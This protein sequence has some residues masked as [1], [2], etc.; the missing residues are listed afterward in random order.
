MGHRGESADS[1]LRLMLVFRLAFTA[2]AVAFAVAGLTAR[3]YAD[4]L[5]VNNSGSSGCYENIQAAIAAV[6]SPAT[7]IVIAPGTYSATCYNP[8]CAVAAVAGS[9]NLNGLTLRCRSVNGRVAVLNAAGL[10]HAIYI[11]GVNSVTVEGCVVENAGREGILVENADNVRIKANE[12]RRNDLSLLHTGGCPSVNPAGAP[13]PGGGIVPF[14]CPDAWKGPPLLANFPDDNDDCGEG[15]H[16]RS[17]TDA[18]VQGNFV[19]GN[20]GGILITDETGV[21]ENNLIF[22]N[23]SR[24]NLGDCGITLAS[25]VEC[26]AGS[27][28]ATGCS[29]GEA[30]AGYGV[31]H[32]SVVGN[33]SI[34]NGAAGVGAFANP[35]A[36]PGAATVASGN[37]ISDNITR[38]NGHPGVSIHAHAG[39]SNL[40]N[41]VIVENVVSGNGGDPESEGGKAPSTIGIELFSASAALVGSGFLPASPIRGTVI[42]QNKVSDEDIDVWVGATQTDARVLLNDLNGAGKTGILN[43]GSGAITGIDNWWSCPQGPGGGSACSNAVPGNGTIAVSPFLRTPVSP[44][45]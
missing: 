18:V 20:A 6:S 40:D 24:N 25:H 7:T 36:P 43:D 8:A 4:T 42:S 44:E 39:N 16:L 35:G 13:M 28:D 45:E 27:T 22:S 38:N 31:I 19:H 11:S 1:V 26:G 3:S 33:R 32:N 30:N 34:G 5:C 12:V 2:A 37:L 21:S 29:S 10:D 15:I 9:S 14:C 17:V 23:L 41:N